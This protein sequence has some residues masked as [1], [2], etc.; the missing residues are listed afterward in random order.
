MPNYAYVSA[1]VLPFLL[2]GLFC[3]P[4][5]RILDT[6]LSR[7]DNQMIRESKLSVFLTRMKTKVRKL[8][9]DADYWNVIREAAFILTEGGTVVFP[10]E[11]VYGV[12]ASAVSSVGLSR[13]REI[14][15]RSEAKPFTVHIGSRLST[16]RFVPDLT[17]IGRR[18]T[19]K[20]WPGPLTLIFRVENV[21]AAPVI[22][23]TSAAYIDA[24][25]HE[26]TIGIRCPDD[27]GAMDLLSEVRVPVV[28]ASA[29]PAGMEAPVDA[30]EALAMLEGQVDLVIDA[31]RTRYAAPSTI[32]R[33]HDDDYE[34]LREGVIEGRTIR[35]LMQT[36]FL[37]VCTGNTCRSPMAEGLLRRFL[38]E[39]LGCTEP[40]LADRGYH[41]ESAGTSAFDGVSASL[42]AINVM[43]KW[44]LDISSHQSQLLTGEQANRADYIF[45][46]TQGHLDRIVAVEPGARERARRLADAD[47]ADPI[48]GSDNDYERCAK[49][50]EEALRRRLEEISL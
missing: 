8:D 11:T 5:T 21:H 27:R 20:A 35:R 33:V 40:A 47:I 22:Q 32:V 34:I 28:A 43:K 46:M 26:G 14:K 16:H 1:N 3:R 2:A 29:N 19:E 42:P 31:G 24:M 17:G 12:G 38:A 18:L 25:Y 44:G 13:L 37:L 39:K 7:F 6:R 50:I 4:N 23:E 45:A 15:Q 36:H 30:D 48:G 9:C 41:V 10:T 49:E